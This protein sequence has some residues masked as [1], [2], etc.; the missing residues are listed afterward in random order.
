MYIEDLR[1]AI[2]T[3]VDILAEQRRILFDTRG[4]RELRQ[5]MAERRDELE[6]LLR[7]VDL[8]VHE[9]PEEDVRERVAVW[10]DDY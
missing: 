3:K 5:A 2:A 8:I 6:G 7:L 4:G 1:D 9:A 10:H